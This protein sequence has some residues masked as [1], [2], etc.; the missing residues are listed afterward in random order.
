MMRKLTLILIAAILIAASTGVE[1][2][3]DWN[4]A[5]FDKNIVSIQVQA[6]FPLT[7]LSR[8]SN[9]TAF[10]I[11][12]DTQGTDWLTSA[13]FLHTSAGKGQYVFGL[14]QD[15]DPLTLVKQTDRYVVLHSAGQRTIEPIEVY[16]G[17]LTQRMAI[18]TAG[19]PVLPVFD[20]DDPFNTGT[21]IIY[22]TSFGQIVGRQNETDRWFF[23][24]GILPGHSGG[25]VFVRVDGREM[26][27]G[28]VDLALFQRV[29]NEVRVLGGSFT[30]FKGV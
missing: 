14:T 25:P 3:Q 9:S 26:L 16:Q 12:S 6:L 21:E 11:H 29:E 4:V 2:A 22:A 8:T 24:P 20:E 17:P 1:F 30:R 5:R 18:Y 27:V 28:I 15:G 7:N 10:A 23:Q 13:D 19:Y